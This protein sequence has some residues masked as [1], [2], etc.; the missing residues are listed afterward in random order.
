MVAAPVRRQIQNADPGGARP[1]R[2]S[3][4]CFQRVRPVHYAPAIKGPV[5]DVVFPGRRSLGAQA[6][7][8][9]ALVQNGERLGRSMVWEFNPK[10]QVPNPKEILNFQYS[11]SAQRRFEL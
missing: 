5:E 7:E 2:L 10:S 8:L 4:R 3:A 1:A 11:N 6:A 9:A